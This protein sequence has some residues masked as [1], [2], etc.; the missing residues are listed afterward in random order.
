[1]RKFDVEPGKCF[2]TA[3]DDVFIMFHVNSGA[4]LLETK[5]VHPE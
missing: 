2:T 5:P 1:M 3:E 4:G